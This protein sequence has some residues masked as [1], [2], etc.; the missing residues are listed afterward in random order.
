MSVGRVDKPYFCTTCGL[1]V[2][3][4]VQSFRISEFGGTMLAVVPPS[5]QSEL[6]CPRVDC[7][8][9]LKRDHRG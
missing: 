7:P 5:S 6:R 9:R 3:I 1:E 4:A 8:G 2:Q